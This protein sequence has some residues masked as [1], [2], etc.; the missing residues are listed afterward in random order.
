ME[1]VPQ[2]RVLVKSDGGPGRTHQGYLSESKL[3]GLVHYP[4]LPNGTMFQELDNTFDYPKTL[5]EKNR[6]KIWDIKFGLH[7]ER[8]KVTMSDVGYILFGGDYPVTPG[9]SCIRLENTFVLGF[10]K[11]RLESAMKI[12][13]YVPATRAAFESG[14][15]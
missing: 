4:G 2:K 10:T 15:L 14:K 3:N 6:L 5:M 9:E 1:D 7:G 8:A 11:G 12:C 13:G